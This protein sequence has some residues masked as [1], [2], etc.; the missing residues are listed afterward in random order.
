MDKNLFDE[1]MKEATRLGE[2][3]DTEW[4][5]EHGEEYDALME[6]LETLYAEG[7]ITAFEYNEIADVAFYD[8]IPKD[9]EAWFARWE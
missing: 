1:L 3:V 9:E 5:E 2:H 8:F 6:R 4:A 7:K